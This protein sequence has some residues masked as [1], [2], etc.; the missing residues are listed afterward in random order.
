MIESNVFQ[1]FLKCI[2]ID[3]TPSLVHKIQQGLTGVSKT[4]V[5]SKVLNK[6]AVLAKHFRCSGPNRA[7]IIQDTRLINGLTGLGQ[8]LK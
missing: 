1:T 5:A 4:G 6:L 7:H 8:V 3:S 2:S